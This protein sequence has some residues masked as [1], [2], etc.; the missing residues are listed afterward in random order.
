M[1]YWSS[2]DRPIRYVGICTK[3]SDHQLLQ[4][5]RTLTHSLNKRKPAPGAKGGATWKDYVTGPAACPSLH[6]RQHNINKFNWRVDDCPRETAT[7][8]RGW[9]LGASSR[10]SGWMGN[11]GHGELCGC[12]AGKPVMDQ[13]LITSPSP[14]PI[15]RL[16]IIGTIV[17]RFGDS[18]DNLFLQQNA[19]P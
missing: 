4:L 11:G 17:G 9:G 3:S 6:P 5:L 13:Q 1:C 8:H 7:K 14:W 18:G 16:V 10:R 15:I 19:C 2:I 12:V